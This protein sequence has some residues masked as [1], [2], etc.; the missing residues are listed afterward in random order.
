MSHYVYVFAS[1]V[2]G[3]HGAP[4][5]IGI[6]K[7]IDIRLR[8]IG[9]ATACPYPLKLYC[10]VEVPDEGIARALEQA[11]HHVERRN[12]T[13]GE[14]FNLAP[15]VAAC[16]LYWAFGTGLAHSGVPHEDI[17]RHWVMGYWGDGAS[18]RLG[19]PAGSV[20]HG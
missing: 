20:G 10:C 9:T 1:L 3:K 6:T 5:K 2:A 7:D 4:V 19:I 11:I 8:Q 14:W 17:A 13:R 18:A 16:C 15:D 12:R